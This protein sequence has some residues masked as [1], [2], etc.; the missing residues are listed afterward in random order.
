MTQSESPLTT[1][2]LI[3]VLFALAMFLGLW[4]VGW[5][6]AALP[7]WFYAYALGAAVVALLG[8]RLRSLDRPER[9]D[10]QRVLLRGFSWGIPFAALISGQR[11]LD[12]DFRQPALALLFLGVWSV[13]CLI[14]GALSV[15]KEKRAAQGNKVAQAAKDWL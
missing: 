2:F 3:A 9:P 5:R 6:F 14:Y 8:S 4:E 1:T 15:C 11:V 10:W 13:I 12:D 7:G